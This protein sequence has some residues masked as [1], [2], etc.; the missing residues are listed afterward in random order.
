MRR[1]FAQVLREGNIDPKKEYQKLHD[2]FYGPS[3]ETSEGTISVYDEL[4]YHFV[5]FYLRDTCL[6]IE[7][8]DSV[9]GFDFS[10]Y[11]NE[12]QLDDLVSF[13]E[14]IQNMLIAYQSAVF[15]SRYGMSLNGRINVQFYFNHISKIIEKIGYQRSEMDGYTIYVES[16]PAA[17]AAA[18]SPLIPEHLSYKLISY[19]HYSM[20]G[21][22]PEKKSTILQLADLLE[23][24]RPELS[25][26]DSGFTSD[27]FYLFNNLN[28]RHNNTDPSLK[29]KY[30]PFIAEMPPEDLENWYDE[31]YQMCLLAFLKLEHADR[32]IKFDELKKNI[33]TK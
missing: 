27:L 11:P 17:N 30:K 6:S 26:I 21:N 8:F 33:E 15:S 31:T 16:N 7:E 18:E 20:K 23:A 2:L 25:R 13:C 12:F 19:N 5:D 32:K 3:I 9:H 14:Y 28:L 4:G 24:K 22:M 1:N 10:K 29:G